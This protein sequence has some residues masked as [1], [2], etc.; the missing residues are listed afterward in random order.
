MQGE[1]FKEESRRL[2]DRL[3]ELG[4]RQ[5]LDSARGIAQYELQTE[6]SLAFVREQIAELNL[7][8]NCRVNTWEEQ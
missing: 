3:D 8:G 6:H 1:R 7:Q 5:T 4:V 2:E